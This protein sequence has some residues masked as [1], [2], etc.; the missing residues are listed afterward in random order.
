MTLQSSPRMP[1]IVFLTLVILIALGGTLIL[2]SRPEPV[3]ITINPP[4]ATATPAPTS[5]TAP[6]MVYVTGE[7]ALPEQLYTLP[8]GSR[9]SDAVAAAGGFTDSANQSLVNMAGIVRDGDQVHVPSI[10]EVDDDSELPTPSGGQLVYINSA[11]QAELVS[12]PNV[13]PAVAE[14]II[15]YREQVS[16]FASLADLDEVPG[17]GEATLEK[18]ADLIGFD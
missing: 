10:R 4:H 6:F 17:I 13:G 16:P 11:T 3:L 7:V 9:V 12:L 1:V 5:T 2:L 14:R 18:L 15:E 8:F